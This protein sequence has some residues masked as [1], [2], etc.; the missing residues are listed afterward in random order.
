MHASQE[1]KGQDWGRQGWTVEPH[2]HYLL[3]GKVGPR[4]LGQGGR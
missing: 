4:R 2:S 3:W 1:S